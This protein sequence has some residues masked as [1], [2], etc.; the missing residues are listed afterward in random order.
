MA[1]HPTR[2][3]RPTLTLPVIAGV[4]LSAILA[5]AG[6]AWARYDRGPTVIDRAATYAAPPPVAGSPTRVAGSLAAGDPPALS[7]SA[8]TKTIVAVL[9]D[10]VPAGSACD[11]PAFGDVYGQRIAATTRRTVTVNNLGTPRQTSG[12]LLASLSA[13][14]TARTVVASADIVTITIGANDFAYSDYAPDSCPALSCY[15]PALQQMSQAVDALLD[16][17]TALRS[18]RRTAV[19]VTGYWDIWKD[20]AVGR[21]QGQQYDTVGDALTRLVNTSLAA[22]AE[23]HGAV[24]V[25]L[26]HAFRGLSGTDD[27]TSLLASDGDHP[28]STGHHQ[29]AEA[30]VQ[31]GLSPLD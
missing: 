8:P 23:A 17:I 12:G 24:Y 25:D 15:Q 19:R 10:S 9:G 7:S 6:C 26:F 2:R 13:N 11:C 21:A 20:G 4:V 30:L 18:G 5:G 27:D 16:R 22:S 28:N 14:G 3:R 1:V 31:S 29:I